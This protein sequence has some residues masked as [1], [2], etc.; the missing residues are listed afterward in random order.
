[1]NKG[2]LDHGPSQENIRR[3]QAEP[4][5]KYMHGE[6]PEFGT[7]IFGFDSELTICT[8]SV[9]DAIEDR[10]LLYPE[11]LAEVNH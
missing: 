8:Q 3:K 10:Y 4:I 6:D 11:L 1:M 5:W 9:R 2:G 7:S